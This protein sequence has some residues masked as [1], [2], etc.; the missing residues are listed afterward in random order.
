MRRAVSEMKP[1][2]GPYHVGIIPSYRCDYGCRFCALGLGEKVRR[3]DLDINL[4][5]PLLEDLSEMMTW[6]ISLTGGGEPSVHPQFKEIIRQIETAGFNSIISTHGR[7]L[8]ND[9]SANLV[10]PRTT[11]H[12]SM[13]A[14]T[15]KTYDAVHQLKKPGTFE[16]LC[17]SIRAISPN[18][19]SAVVG[20]VVISFIFCKENC[21]EISEFYQLAQHI[22]A[23]SVVY[24]MIIPHPAY[25]DLIPTQEEIQT[26]F[27]D[28]DEI[29]KKAEIPGNPEVVF[30]DNFVPG[31]SNLTRVRHSL[32]R[33]LG[34]SREQTTITQLNDRY[35]AWKW[36]TTSFIP[37]LEGF[38]NSYIDSDGSVFACH[39]GS[40]NH[41]NNVM[42]SLKEESFP[43]IWHGK[44]YTR[45]RDKT[46]TI[47]TGI[48]GN[49]FF[50]DEDTCLRCPKRNLFANIL[51]T[52]RLAPSKVAKGETNVK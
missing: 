33:L 36:K 12:I 31:R 30:G 29:R 10:S 39:G 27:K 17:Q 41:P 7:W 16:A 22:G 48:A 28:L 15:S 9:R 52:I 50:P 25:Q 51:A 13:N 20:K 45:F 46:A 35:L 1:E 26:A 23:D 18:T 2:L 4:L 6:E 43:S 11:I 24:R 49:S 14:A 40:S 42:G 21:K 3:P 38:F 19:G 8:I 34:R 32:M 37:C 5:G 44:R 47:N